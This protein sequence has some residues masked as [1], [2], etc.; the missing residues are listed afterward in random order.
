MTVYDFVVDLFNS[1]REGA[2]PMTI[3]DAAADI[4]N[5]K[6]EGWQL[7]EG[8]TPEEYAETWNKLCKAG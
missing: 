7:P 6:R 1:C 5:F 8:I 3:D 4:E 2:E